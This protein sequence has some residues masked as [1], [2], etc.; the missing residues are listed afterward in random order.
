[1]DDVVTY[2]HTYVCTP[3]HSHS[4]MLSI[5]VKDVYKASNYHIIAWNLMLR[6]SKISVTGHNQ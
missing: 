6:L 4:Q 1:M 3:F 5:K 2:I